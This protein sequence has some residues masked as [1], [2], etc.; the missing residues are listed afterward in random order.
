M[1]RTSK[2]DAPDRATNGG[3]PAVIPPSPL[4]SYQPACKPGSVGRGFPRVTAIP[5]R[6]RLPGASSNLPGRLVRTDWD[7]L[8]R[9]PRHPYSV[10][11]PVGFAVPLPLPVARC[12]LTAPFHPYRRRRG[13]AGGLILCGTFP[14]VAP[15]GRYPAPFVRGARTFLPGDLSVLAGAAVQPTDGRNVGRR[16]ESGV[17]G[18]TGTA[19]GCAAVESAARERIYVTGISGAR[20]RGSH[21]QRFRGPLLEGHRLAGRCWRSTSST[22][23]APSSGRRRRCSRSISTSSSIRA[24][25]GR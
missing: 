14:G 20:S 19:I 7:P 10:L 12:A 23:G 11:L 18:G 22:S 16:R 6:R 3:G 13:A 5:L 25:R 1:I 4:H 2:I 9:L 8:A 15:A 17:N 21:E 24:A